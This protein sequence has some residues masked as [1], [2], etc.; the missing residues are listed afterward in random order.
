MS[1][2]KHI[3]VFGDLHDLGG[4][5][6]DQAVVNIT[7]SGTTFTATRAD[8]TTF[9]FTQQD[10]NTWQ[11]NTNTQE[12]YVASGS[13]QANKVW[14]TDANG[15]PAWRDDA[16]TKYDTSIV[17]ITRNGT[18]FTATRA[19]GTTFTFTQQDN[20][21]WQANSKSVAGYVNAGTYNGAGPRMWMTDAD[22][23][24]AWRKPADGF[25]FWAA[26]KPDNSGYPCYLL[27]Y[28]I[29]DWRT[30]D[31][32]LYNFPKAGFVGTVVRDRTGG[33]I[34]PDD[35]ANIVMG[36]SYRYSATLDQAFIRLR[37]THGQIRPFVLYNGSDKYWLALRVD[38]SG[39]NLHFMGVRHGTYIGTWLNAT[40]STGTPPS[41]YNICYPYLSGPTANQIMKIGSTGVPEWVTDEATTTTAGT[42]TWN[43]A[44]AKTDYGTKVWRVG[45]NGYLYLNFTLSSYT[46]G[47]T[48]VTLPT[49]FRPIATMDFNV[50]P[51]AGSEHPYARIEDGGPVKIMGNFTAGTSSGV[52]ALISYPIA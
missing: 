19:D 10:L 4:G 34:G 27:F 25:D 44:V 9:T 37:S 31:G 8:G 52:R 21:T 32:S 42:L 17:N 22:G 39:C 49:G 20:N 7:R 15:N 43:T 33:S 1:E 23:N 2:I 41:G 45:K 3:N 12:G 47:T 6:T 50:F 30:S 29:S 35:V 24:P 13:G 40:D 51:N 28:D 48:I 26:S 5:G 18:T 11:A 46:L 14:K 16:D 36:A 38:G